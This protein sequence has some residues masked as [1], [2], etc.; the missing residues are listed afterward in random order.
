MGVYITKKQ[1]ISRQSK[2]YFVFNSES[3]SNSLV[4]KNPN[5]LSGADNFTTWAAIYSSN[6]T[7]INVSFNLFSLLCV[8]RDGVF[9]WIVAQ[10][11]TEA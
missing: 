3:E 5:V 9:R 11:T 7:M 6:S 8:R 1:E 2:S 4:R 10:Y